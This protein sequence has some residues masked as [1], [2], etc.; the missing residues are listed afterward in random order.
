M[1]KTIIGLSAAAMAAGLGFGAA[2]LATADDETPAPTVSQSPSDSQSPGD[3]RFGRDH[4]G[5]PRMQS[6]G[7]DLSGLAEK[8]G[9]KEQ[10]LA[11]AMESARE[12]TRPAEHPSKPASAEE[13]EAA[14]AE[15]QAA[16]AKAL[17]EELGLDEQ[18][19]N[20]ALTEL[21]E[22]HQQSRREADQAVLDQAVSD[23]TLTQAEADAVA[24]AI[25]QGIVSTRGAGPRR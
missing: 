7:L 21:R 20:D 11:D 17:A 14:Q 22:E 8:L 19:V 16:L 6:R 3:G 1:K 5:G 2:S 24:K 18:Q 13:W 10:A 25:E 15:H 9:V 23:G 4:G 12:A